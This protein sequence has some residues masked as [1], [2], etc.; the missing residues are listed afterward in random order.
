VNKTKWIMA[1]LMAAGVAQAA[2]VYF[3]DFQDD[4]IGAKPV[5]GAGNTGSSNA[6]YGTVSIQANP[7]SS[8]N[9]STQVSR[10]GGKAV[11]SNRIY[12]YF[13]GGAQPIDGMT[14]SYDFYSTG[15]TNANNGV[16][17]GLM[18]TAGFTGQN[19]DCYIRFDPSCFVRIDAVK[20]NKKSY[21]SDVWQHFTG[22]LTATDLTTRTYN[23][24]WTLRNLET[25]ASIS[26]TNSIVFSDDFSNGLA[27]AVIAE[28]VDTDDEAT[29][30]YSYIDNIEVLATPKPI[31]LGM[32][33]VKAPVFKIL[34]PKVPFG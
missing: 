14:F 32:L 27:A 8:G 10:G 12:G 29:D 31:T 1:A 26:G 11:D 21:G 9:T 20:Q 4:A 6:I 34:L 23:L 5:I 15:T 30:A 7:K 3:D 25:V 19:G 28:V 18:Q 2:T 16:R 22:T 33:R 24:V 13:N 17:F